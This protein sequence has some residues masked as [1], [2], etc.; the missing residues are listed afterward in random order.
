MCWDDA[1][2]ESDRKVR[3]MI[4][5]PFILSYEMAQADLLILSFPYGWKDSDKGRW[6]RKN[7]EHLQEVVSWQG[8]SS[9]PQLIASVVQP[10]SLLIGEVWSP[11]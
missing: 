8:N 9:K 2:D 3:T 6:L 5:D 11:H 10:S 7:R 1:R 4:F